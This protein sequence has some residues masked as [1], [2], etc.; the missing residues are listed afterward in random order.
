MSGAA[1]FLRPF[2]LLAAIAFVAGFFGYLALGQ[3]DRAVA[4]ISVQPAAASGP[5]SEDWNLPHH[6]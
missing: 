3:P 4:Q 5:A 1:T 6:I 2:A